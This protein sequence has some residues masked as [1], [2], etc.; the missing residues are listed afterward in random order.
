MTQQELEENRRLATIWEERENIEP[1]V[2]RVFGRRML[3]LLAEID[4][5]REENLRYGAT[6]GEQD[7]EILGLRAA[8][9]EARRLKE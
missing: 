1:A 8:L 5:L 7:N 9:A 4:R 6:I 3:A 2:P